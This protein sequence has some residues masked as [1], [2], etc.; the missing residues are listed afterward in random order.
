LAFHHRFDD[1]DH[2]FDELFFVTDE[3]KAG[4]I[5]A[6]IIALGRKADT[7]FPVVIELKVKRQLSRLIEQLE[8]A[9]EAIRIAKD[10]SREFLSAVTGIEKECISSEPRLILLW[11]TLSQEERKTVRTARGS[12]YITAE[13][14]PDGHIRFAGEK[15]TVCL[16]HGAGL[17]DCSVETLGK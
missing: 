5:R 17:A 14:H 7:Y 10:D 8:A 1:F 15:P 11:P 6:D 9:K 16:T 3:F 12:G 13:F 2:V 4:D